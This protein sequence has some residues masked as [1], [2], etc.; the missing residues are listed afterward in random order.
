MKQELLDTNVLLRFL[1]GDNKKQQRQAELWFQEA[2]NRKRKIIVAPLIIAEAAFVLESF[3]K[4][5]RGEIADSL[6]LFTSQRWLQVENREV[7]IHV[8]P[9]YIKGLHFVD[10]FLLAWIEVHEGGILT[11]D[12]QLRKK[13]KIALK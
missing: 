3:Y 11:F 12:Q 6:E 8:W 1:V 2:E 9:W 13:K 4:K 5:G 10:S 7:I